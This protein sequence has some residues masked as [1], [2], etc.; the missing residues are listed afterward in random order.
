[1]D[2]QAFVCQVMAHEQTLYRVA[3]SM[4]RQDADRKD[5]V[6][7]AVLKAWSNH[8]KLKEERYFT[9]WLVRILINECHKICRKQ[10]RLVLIPAWTGEKP[11][12]ETNASEGELTVMVDSLPDKLRLPMVLHYVEGFP[13]KDIADMLRCPLGTV[14]KRLHDGRK[15]LRLA[16]EQDEEAWQG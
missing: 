1:M 5:A 4:L 9:T 2:K 13:L 12:I 3:C 10:A 14:K 6:Q 15:A 16:Y 8:H 7:E 11:P